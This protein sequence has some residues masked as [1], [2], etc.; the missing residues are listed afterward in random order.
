MCVACSFVY[1]LDVFFYQA[2]CGWAFS[3]SGCSAAMHCCCTVSSLLLCCCCRRCRRRCC[4]CRAAALPCCNLLLH[5]T[6]AVLLLCHAAAAAVL[7]LCHAAAAVAMLHTLLSASPPRHA[8][9]DDERYIPRACLIDLEP[10]CVGR[11]RCSTHHNR[12]LRSWPLRRRSP[13]CQLLQGTVGWAVLL[14][15][16]AWGAAGGG[17]VAGARVAGRAPGAV[18]TLLLTLR[19]PSPQQT[20]CSVINGIQNSEVRCCTARSVCS[21]AAVQLQPGGG[22]APAADVH[23]AVEPHPQDAQLAAPPCF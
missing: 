6:A 3:A 1:Y 2:R 7:L 23:G 21:C 9:A 22:A 16:G 13:R 4:C 11:S 5:C 17:Q 15:A 12:L 8:Q 14:A 18:L 10:R 20:S 19:C